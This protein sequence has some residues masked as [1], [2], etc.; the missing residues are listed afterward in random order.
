M[1]CHCL[2]LLASLIVLLRLSLYSNKVQCYL[3]MLRR[4]LMDLT[5][6]LFKY[7]WNSKDS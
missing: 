4:E 5:E 6:S 7:S 3:E 2:I 1:N